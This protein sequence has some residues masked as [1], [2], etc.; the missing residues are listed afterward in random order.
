MND[1]RRSLKYYE[2]Q[3]SQSERDNWFWKAIYS[4]N[5]V[6]FFFFNLK[7]QFS[8]S[9]VVSDYSYSFSSV[10]ILSVLILHI[11]AIFFS[12]L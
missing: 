12:V 11:F 10:Y 6:S 3:S 8:R 7:F 9:F 4:L 5:I 1:N 2:R